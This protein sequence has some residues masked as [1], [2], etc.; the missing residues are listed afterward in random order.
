M[1]ESKDV[2]GLNDVKKSEKWDFDDWAFTITGIIV[3]FLMV[4][5]DI[6]ESG[7]GINILG[8]SLGDLG[9]EIVANAEDG[10]LLI[11][12]LWQLRIFSP[13][14]FL[15]TTTICFIKDAFD[16]RKTGGYTGSVFTHTFESLVEDAI[17]MAITTAMVYIGIITGR[18]YSSWLAGPITWVLF[19]FIFPFVKKKRGIDVEDDEEDTPWLLLI[20]LLIG[21]IAEAITGVWIAFPMSWLVICVIKLKDEVR[22]GN[23]TIDSIFNIMYYTFSIV[24][25]TIGI[26]R[27]FWITSWTAFP[28]ALLICWILSKFKRFKKVKTD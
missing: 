19:I 8:G 1:E 10:G 16:A 7:F 17:Y 4:G 25:L 11:R 2:K 12:S 18:M 13:M 3:G 20:I 14:L 15:L 9:E 26:I 22:E 28:I 24:L 5:P 6:L 27:D 21:I 23:Y